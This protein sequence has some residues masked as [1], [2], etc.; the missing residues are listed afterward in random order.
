MTRHI[1]T[2]C[3]KHACTLNSSEPADKRI[4][5]DAKST[6][7][8]T[9]VQPKISNA[10]KA[11]SEGAYKKM[12]RTAYTLTMEATLPSRQFKTLVKCQREN[13]VRLIDGKFLIFLFR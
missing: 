8:N 12:L 3:H 10:L 2:D 1:N 4:R 6:G 13:G 9:L 5:L 7:S 11:A